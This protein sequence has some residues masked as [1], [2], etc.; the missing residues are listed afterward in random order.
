MH[1]NFEVYGDG[2]PLILI[3]G[4]LGALDNWRSMSKRLAIRFRVYAVDLRNHG[5]SPH[6]EVMN[7]SVMAHDLGEFFTTQAI[8]SAFVLGHSL[9]GKIAMQF[10]LEFPDLVDRL[11]VADI[12]PKAYP[13]AHKPLLAA[14]RQL[15]VSTLKSYAEADAALAPAIG[16][17]GLRQFVIKNLEH[18]SDG[19]FRWRIALD[20]IIANYDALT[21]AIPAG[22]K[23][24][25]PV[26]FLRAGRSNYIEESDLALIHSLFPRA[27]LVAIPDAG[28]W[29]HIEAPD[30]FFRVVTEFLGSS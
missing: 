10:A 23:F 29:L 5:H 4:F 15:N 25:K 28:H 16:D 21:Q 9:G 26:C 14:L 18:S 8:E 11:I 27:E 22:T 3:H 6:D 30:E 17:A 12:A 7:Y 19:S 20:A 2:R 1:L 24:D 13:P